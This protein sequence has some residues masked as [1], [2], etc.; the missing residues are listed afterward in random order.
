MKSKVTK[1]AFGVMFLLYENF[2]PYK[3]YGVN[4]FMAS[5]G[6]SVD[7]KYRGRS[8]GDHFLATRKLL[9]KEFE[10]K[11]TQT[12]FT[13]DFSNRNADKVGFVPNVIMK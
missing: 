6:L 3:H 5:L 12:F 10:L 8:I 13:S 7:R 4:E 2:D 1:N 11:F 9:C